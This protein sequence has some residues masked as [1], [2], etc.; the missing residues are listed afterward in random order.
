MNGSRVRHI[1]L[2]E[3]RKALP[4]V[5]DQGDTELLQPLASPVRR[6]AGGT[7]NLSG[8]VSRI[9]A[10]GRGIRNSSLTNATNFR[11]DL[12]CLSPGNSVLGGSDVVRRRPRRSVGAGPLWHRDTALKA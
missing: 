3:Q 11:P 4:D 6:I 8:R 7:V 10:I 9:Q 12:E 2:V 5:L 1:G